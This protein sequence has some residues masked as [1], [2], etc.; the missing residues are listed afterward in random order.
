MGPLSSLE[1]PD[2]NVSAKL[3]EGIGKPKNNSSPVDKKPAEGENKKTED[4]V[5]SREES[6]LNP[7]NIKKNEQASNIVPANKIVAPVDS[8]PSQVET[9]TT[10]EGGMLEYD[11][12]KINNISTKQVDKIAGE[13][14][15][16]EK[17]LT[18]IQTLADKLTKYTKTYSENQAVR[19]SIKDQLTARG[20]VH[21]ETEPKFDDKE[22]ITNK[23]E[24]INIDPTKKEVIEKYENA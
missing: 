15:K 16:T 17:G 18:K 10:I 6:P 11:S 9:N 22:N 23:K 20:S 12:S 8:E 2:I 14:K 24:I 3:M 13:F 19:T 4:K 7:V 21:P 1:N 5:I